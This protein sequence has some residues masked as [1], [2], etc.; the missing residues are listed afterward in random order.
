M[1]LNRYIE[2][3]LLKQD[4]TKAEIINLFDEAKKYKFFGVCINPS[5]VKLAK[6]YLKDTDIKVVT[7]VGFPLGQTTCEA[8]V[9]E[10]ID[11]V[12]NGADEIDMVLNCGKLKDGEYDYIV[13]EIFDIKTACQG[14]NLKVILETDLLTSDEIKTA[15]EL[16]IKGGANFVKTSTGFVKNGVGAKAEDVKLMHDTVHSAGLGVKASGGIR[17]KETALKMVDA[18]AVRLGTS[19]GV[20]IVTDSN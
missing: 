2:H 12:K 5:F 1:E 3:T 15:C 8:K 14:K 7:V 16:C 19:S 11:A 9:L 10:T 18:G 17:D 4:A 13:S 20:K 6:Q